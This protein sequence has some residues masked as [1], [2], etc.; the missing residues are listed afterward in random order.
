MSNEQPETTKGDPNLI[1]RWQVEDYRPV[2]RRL[3]D[4]ACDDS[5]GN[6]CILG[7]TGKY[8]AGWP[9]HEQIVDATTNSIMAL[10]V[11][12][13]KLSSHVGE[14]EASPHESQHYEHSPAP[15]TEQ[16]L[17]ERKS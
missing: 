4:E 9:T 5:H 11:E 1:A 14:S 2:V 8:E 12:D 16:R 10:F 7:R 15:I 3:V 6:G 17:N 13:R